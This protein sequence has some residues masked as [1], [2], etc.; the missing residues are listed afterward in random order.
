MNLAL[1]QDNTMQAKGYAARAW[2]IR[3]RPGDY[4]SEAAA[5][6]DFAL[7]KIIEE[8]GGTGCRFSATRIRSTVRSR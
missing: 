7:R 6:D 4:M 8:V 3:E 5:W 2:Q 1:E